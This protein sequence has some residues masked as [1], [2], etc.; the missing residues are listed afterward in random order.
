MKTLLAT[1]VLFFS[2]QASAST[3]A[4]LT[5]VAQR[6]NDHLTNVLSDPDRTKAQVRE[7]MIANAQAQAAATWACI[8]ET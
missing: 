7:A 4:T 8:G 2:L 5:A 6:A 1:A 3:C